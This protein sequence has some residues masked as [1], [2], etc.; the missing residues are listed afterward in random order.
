MSTE[1]N[2]SESTTTATSTAEE[3]DKLEELRERKRHTGKV[4]V[5]FFTAQSSDVQATIV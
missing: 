3:T 5:K 2:E 1:A 4:A